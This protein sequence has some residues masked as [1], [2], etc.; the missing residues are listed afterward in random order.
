MDNE[1]SE[2][3]VSRV[4]SRV[5]AFRELEGGKR[6]YVQVAGY[7]L[8]RGMYRSRRVVGRRPTVWTYDRD[9][10]NLFTGPAAAKK[11]LAFELRYGVQFESVKATCDITEHLYKGEVVSRWWH[12]FKL[13]QS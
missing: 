3:L 11:D 9:A 5:I 13:V 4:V 1:R 7:K 2:R 8:Y 12:N 10:A 6:Q